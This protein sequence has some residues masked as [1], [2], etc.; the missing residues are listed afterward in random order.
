MPERVQKLL[1]AA[2]H[3]SRREIEGWIREGRLAIDGR[4]AEL[5]DRVSGTE[6]IT[7]D[8][9]PL[10]VRL[11]AA[12]HRHIL[13]HKPDNEITTRNDPEGRRT[14]F[15]SVPTLVGA[16]WVAVG[17]LDYTTTGVLLFTTDGALANKLMHPS[18][19]LLRRYAVRVLGSPTQA[20]LARLREG[21]EL[22]DGMAAFET[23]EAAGGEG[24]NRWFNVTLREGRNREVRRLWEGI[25]YQVSRL[26]RTGYGP[27]DLPR[28]LRRG[29]FQALTPAQVRLLYRAAGMNPPADVAAVDARKKHRKKRRKPR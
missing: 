22:D 1:A 25:G 19:G 26:I 2:G 9:R 8:K 15:E 18:S 5:G 27:I 12:V 17:R 28:A 16:R 24:S 29:R 13:Y 20:E 3:G 4:V 10:A 14:V 23:I 11:A 6:R 21:I 7:L